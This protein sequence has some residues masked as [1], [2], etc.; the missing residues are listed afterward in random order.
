M[1]KEI[2]EKEF[3]PFFELMAVVTKIKSSQIIGLECAKP[4]MGV[5]HFIFSFF[6][7]FHWVGRFALSRKPDAKCPRN[8]G[9]FLLAEFVF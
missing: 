6:S 2:D 1:I 3:E 5:F 4:G 8:E 7:K 9:Q